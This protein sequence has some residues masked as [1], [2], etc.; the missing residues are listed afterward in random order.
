[1]P[2]NK[3]HH[4]VPRFFLKRFSPDEDHIH[5]YNIKRGK[6]ILGAGLYE[7]CAKNYFYG[8][9]PE[10]E[11]L[12]AGA[13]GEIAGLFRM[14]DHYESPPP[15][16]T[17]PHDAFL[18]HI[19]LQRSRTTYAVAALNESLDKMMKEI[20]RDHIKETMGIDLDEFTVE[21]T[22]PAVYAIGIGNASVSADVRPPIEAANERYERAIHH[23]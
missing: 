1:M 19:L 2:D 18:I 9:T 20:Y 8:K 14:I 6:V 13:E 15:R 3:R 10:Y 7:Q 12:L 16:M 23:E 17:P 22:N 4:Y 21:K 11:K 5:M